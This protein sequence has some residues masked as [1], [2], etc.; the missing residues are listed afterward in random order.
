MKKRTLKR[1]AAAF[2]TGAMMVATLGMSVCAE[3]VENT[4]VSGEAAS[5][6]IA[7]IN[8]YLIMEANANVPNVTFTYKITPGTAVDATSTTPQILAGV[9]AE[10][11]TIGNTEF[12]TNDSTSTDATPITAAGATLDTGEKYATKTATVD[13]SDVTFDNPGIYRYVITEVNDGADGFTYATNSLYMDVY[14]VTNDNGALSVAGY[15]L[16]KTT[17]VADNNGT[18][19]GTNEKSEAFINKYT[20]NDLTIQKTVTGNQGNKGQY[21]EFTVEIITNKSNAGDKYTVDL[22]NASE[23]NNA[24]ELTVGVDG[25]VTAT[26]KLKHNESIIIKG[27]TASTT[28]KVTEVLNA[29]EGYTTTYKIDG[30]TAT[31]GLATTGLDTMADDA[32]VEFTNNKEVTTPTGI[33][34]TFAPYVLMVAFAAVVAF[35]FLRRR[36][37]EI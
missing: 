2:L 21:F 26:Y 13:F 37:R 29:T 10:K 25:N 11:V 16:H 32:T 36:N 23:N 27:M 12:T 30:G 35:F 9:E 33:I 22:V 24:E 20:T 4:S 31:T 15:V 6:D 28:Y 5:A 3:G 1:L 19:T 18:Y 8:K 17:E 7:L 34:T 14:V